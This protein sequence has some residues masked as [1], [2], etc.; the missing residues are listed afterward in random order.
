MDQPELSSNE[1]YST[2][3]ARGK[4]QKELDDLIN[5]WTKTKNLKEIELLC[6]DNGIPAGLIYKAKDMIED[7]HFKARQA[8]IDITHP[9]FGKI[10]MQ[11][12]APKLSNN[13]GKVY[14]VGPSLG[15]HNNYVFKEILQKSEDEIKHIIDEN[16]STADVELGDKNKKEEGGMDLSGMMK[17]MS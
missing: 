9:E 16:F 17:M 4:N 15:E 14:K 3:S 13:P 10:K 12:V 11:N 8:I 5:D 1:K 7:P 2:H 6:N